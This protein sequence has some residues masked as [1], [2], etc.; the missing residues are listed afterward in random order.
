M[1]HHAFAVSLAAL[2]ILLFANHVRSGAPPPQ[3]DPAQKGIEVL[4]PGL[5]HE[6]F[7]IPVT[8]DPRPNPT[9]YQKPPA[10]I[11]LPPDQKPEGAHIRWIPGYF[12]WDEVCAEC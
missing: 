8:V 6:A 2:G 12:A 3:E 11:E 5:I 10:A 4:T 7:A 9:I 1:N